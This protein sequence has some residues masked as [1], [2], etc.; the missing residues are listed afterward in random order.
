[1][2]GLAENLLK[3]AAFRDWIEALEWEPEDITDIAYDR[4][5]LPDREA[6]A[7]RAD[8]WKCFKAGPHATIKICQGQETQEAIF[9]A[10]GNTWE[11]A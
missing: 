5:V 6:E 8:G 7:K 3:I 9:K 1:M 4:E 2:A 10:S 11:R